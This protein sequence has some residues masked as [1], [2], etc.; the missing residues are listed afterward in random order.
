M[1]AFGS[2]EELAMLRAKIAEAMAQ[3]MPVEF[4]QSI[5]DRMAESLGVA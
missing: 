1:I 3:G 4:W 5:A 2:I